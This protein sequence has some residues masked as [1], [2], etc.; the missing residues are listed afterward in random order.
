MAV[1]GA[2][3]EVSFAST[4]LELFALQPRLKVLQLQFIGPHLPLHLHGQSVQLLDPQSSAKGRKGCATACLAPLTAV[5]LMRIAQRELRWLK[6]RPATVIMH[7][8]PSCA[9]LS[10]GL[11]PP[12]TSRLTYETQIGP[13][14]AGHCDL[15][16]GLGA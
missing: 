8:A 2:E 12:R 6:S 16:A 3:A 7:V 11:S 1:I 15:C 5:C 4:F 14:Q 13:L 9:A 10:H